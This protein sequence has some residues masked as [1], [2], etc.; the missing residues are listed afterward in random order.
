MA[1]HE[2]S[3]SSSASSDRT[4]I[5]SDGREVDYKRTSPMKS[6]RTGTKPTNVAAITRQM[7]GSSISS[8]GYGS[9]QK[10]AIPLKADTGFDR[11]SGAMTGFALGGRGTCQGEH[12]C[13]CCLEL[14]W[15][16]SL[17]ETL[18]LF[19]CDCDCISNGTAATRGLKVIFLVFAEGG[20]GFQRSRSSAAATSTPVLLPM[21]RD[22]VS[23]SSGM[24]K[25]L[26][27]VRH[28][29]PTFSNAWPSMMGKRGISNP[30]CH[31]VE[32]LHPK[33]PLS[34]FLI[35][36]VIWCSGVTS[37]QGRSASAADADARNHAN[38]CH[39]GPF[40]NKELWLAMISAA[41]RCG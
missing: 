8:P 6:L 25:S 31:H 2:S 12:L 27:S 3:R 32:T 37:D 17:V 20:T 38:P 29:S 18:G 14:E 24:P 36:P 23:S 28:S 35:D 16:G 10:P 1:T 41:Q 22:A 19:A 9:D 30:N 34:D 7:A 15:H 33:Q 11:F 39:S 21:R 13:R 40:R 4:S 26:G 5:R